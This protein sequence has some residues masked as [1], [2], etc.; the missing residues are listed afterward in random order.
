MDYFRCWCVP[1]VLCSLNLYD[2]EELNL[3][4]GTFI[5]GHD[6]GTQDSTAMVYIYVSNQGDYY[7]HD[8]YMANARTTAQHFKAFDKLQHSDTKAIQVGSYGDPSAAQSMLDLRRTYNYDIQKAY[9]KIAPS[10]QL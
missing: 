4:G 1:C 2:P 8:T 5:T 7:V 10:I 6:F 9:N 3:S